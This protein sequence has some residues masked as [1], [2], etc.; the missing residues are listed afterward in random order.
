MKSIKVKEY[1]QVEQHKIGERRRWVSL[2][3]DIYIERW[4]CKRSKQWQSKQKVTES[5]LRRITSQPYGR[6]RAKN[7]ALFREHRSEKCQLNSAPPPLWRNLIT[8]TE[9]D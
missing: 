7:G 2:E 6:R 9:D 5:V 8:Q 1:C 4:L 3:L